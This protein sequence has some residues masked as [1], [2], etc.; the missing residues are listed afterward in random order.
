MSLLLNG[1]GRVQ[2]LIT[3]SDERAAGEWFRNNEDLF[4]P[5]LVPQTWENF[6]E[7]SGF[8][9][10]WWPHRSGFIGGGDADPFDGC[11]S[12]GTQHADMWTRSGAN[13][14]LA[15]VGFSRDENGN[16]VP[17]CSIKCFRTADDSLQASVLSDANGYYQATT[18]Y[19]EAHYLVIQM[20]TTPP[21]SGAS[22]ATILP[23]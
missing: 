6:A 9:S 12:A 3:A 17:G 2:L 16:I 11:D 7:F 4:L 18:P 14:R 23:G 19:Y 20:P 21:R 1:A 8:A 10:S 15:F 13:G 5:R 22:L